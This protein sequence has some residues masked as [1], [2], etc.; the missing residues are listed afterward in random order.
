MAFQSPTNVFTDYIELPVPVKGDVKVYRIESVS[1][2][3]GE[4]VQQL[5]GLMVAQ[6]N[7][8][9]LT[10]ADAERLKLDDDQE[11]EFKHSLLG[12]AYDEMIADGVSWQAM[13]VV[14]NTVMVWT[15]NG[16]E[17][18]EAAWEAAMVKAPKA[19]NRAQK[20]AGAKSTP[21]QASPAGTTKTRKK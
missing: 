12:P 18:A 2:R 3:A 11:E 15:T 9:V 17:A 14:V 6:Q 8:A 16:I 5:V 4:F 19:P 21:N 10:E 7:G 1:I 13:R 20:R